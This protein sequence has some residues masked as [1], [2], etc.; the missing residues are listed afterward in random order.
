MSIRNTVVLLACVFSSVIPAAAQDSGSHE[1]E[2]PFAH[3]GTGISKARFKPGTG[4]YLKDVAEYRALRLQPG[5]PRTLRAGAG[6]DE[7]TAARIWNQYGGLIGP[8]SVRLGVEPEAAIAV[9]AVESGGRPFE[10]GRPVIRF[11]VHH[12]WKHWGKQNPEAFVRNFRYRAG[13]NQPTLDH[14]FRA[15]PGEPWT[16]LHDKGQEREWKA[17]GL[18]QNLNPPAAIMSAS[19]GMGQVMGMH[20]GRLGYRSPQKMAESFSDP[21]LGP[22][23]QILGAFDFVLG[24]ENASR[25]LTAFR[26][27]NW[28]E[29]ARRYNGTEVE[30]YA[31]RLRRYYTAAT[32]LVHP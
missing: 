17:F 25:A 30:V 22:H 9:I 12:F 29:F 20:Y 18:A 15:S 24:G 10:N 6:A 31:A 1:K 7:K 26:T 2:A 8:L 16:D 32:R 4:T 13:V 11:E 28:S 21:A 27:R 3:A 5:T 14:Q 19:W 23:M